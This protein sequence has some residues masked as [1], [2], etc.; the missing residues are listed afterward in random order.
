MSPTRRE[1]CVPSI[2]HIFPVAD[3]VKSQ[4]LSKKEKGKLVDLLGGEG[5][6]LKGDVSAKVRPDHPTYI[7][8]SGPSTLQQQVELACQVQLGLPRLLQ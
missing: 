8:H 1:M 5:K 2:L 6:G 7:V 4:R 3:S